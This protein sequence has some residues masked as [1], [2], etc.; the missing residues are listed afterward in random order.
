MFSPQEW[1]FNNGVL[2]LRNLLNDAPLPP[3][4]CNII[5][6]NDFCFSILDFAQSTGGWLPLASR[7]R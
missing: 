5:C 3:F 1:C 4:K 7:I 2:H 6:D